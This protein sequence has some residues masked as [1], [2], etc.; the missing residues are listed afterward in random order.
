[1]RRLLLL[2]VIL[3]GSAAPAF[4]QP[5]P[6]YTITIESPGSVALGDVVLRVRVT[7]GVREVEGAAYHLRNAGAWSEAQS[8]RLARAGEDLFED[9]IATS[10]LPNDG[11]RIEVRVWSDVPPYDPT[12]P[13]TYAR[14]VVDVAVD[15][16]PP[17]PEGVQ[18]LSPA[19]ALRVGWRA[20]PT[21]DRDDF[22]GYR[23]FLRKGRSCPAELDAY[24]QV[25]EVQE[26]L[27]AAETL[28]PGDY[29]VR[30]AAARISA[31]TDVVLSSPSAA[32]RIEVAKGNDPMVQGGGIV[33]ETTEEAVPPPP[34]PLGE[35]ETVTS[36]GEFIE[37]LPYGSQTVTQVAEG[38]PSDEAAARE[39]GVDPRRTPTLIAG[40]L[41][42]VTLAGQLRRF[43]RAAPGR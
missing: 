11:Y 33:F 34:P 2:A 23:V 25:A 18:G 12:D 22:L 36:D 20:V 17:Q 27:Y 15:N 6:S 3:G 32:V 16:P 38:A 21:A 43:L 40:A 7:G 39:A 10:E 31:V 42:L 8:I 26:L 5:S 19:T 35:G 1:M 37:D 29:C 24:T 13:R 14:A 30:V 28:R 41:I 9:P 4:A